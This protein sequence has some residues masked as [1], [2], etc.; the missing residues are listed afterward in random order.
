MAESVNV[1]GKDTSLN[2]NFEY[3]GGDVDAHMSTSW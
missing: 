3:N 1:N 2:L